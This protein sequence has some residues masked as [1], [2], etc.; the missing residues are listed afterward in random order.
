MV[1]PHCTLLYLSSALLV[2]AAPSLAPV[3]TSASGTVCP[4]GWAT[5]QRP[6]LHALT[7]SDIFDPRL[8][9]P[10][11]TAGRHGLAPN[12]LGFGTDYGWGARGG[13]QLHAFREYVFDRTEPDDVV[14]IFDAFDVMVLAGEDE[15]VAAY[16]AIEARSGRQMIYSAEMVCS[17]LRKSEYPHTDTPWKYLN[18]GIMMGR[19]H[20]MRLLFKD[21]VESVVVAPEFK[22]ANGRLRLQNWHTKFFLDNQGSV[23]LDTECELMQVVTSVEGV[24]VRGWGEDEEQSVRGALVVSGGRLRNTITNTTPLILH[25]PGASHWPDFRHPTRVG[26]CLLY[27]VFRILGNPALTELM[28]HRSVNRVPSKMFGQPPWKPVC[29]FYVSP[30]DYVGLRFSHLGDWIIRVYFNQFWSALAMLTLVLCFCTRGS[31]LILRFRL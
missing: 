27:E 10:L 1:A 11:A 9:L 6:R 4:T 7:F 5:G 30:F 24:D 21:R 31:L 14:L 2:P 12:V 8:A 26:T 3:T 17:S 18:G 25:F 29:A 19:S 20:V 16:L 13:A 28:E 22:D 23:M 15:L